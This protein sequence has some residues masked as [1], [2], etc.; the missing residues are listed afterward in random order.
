MKKRWRRAGSYTVEAALVM[1]MILFVLAGTMGLGFRAAQEL[2][3]QIQT[4]QQRYMEEDYE[5]WPEVLRKGQAVAD[6]FWEE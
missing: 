6:G 2:G 3:T 1:P 5:L 4:F